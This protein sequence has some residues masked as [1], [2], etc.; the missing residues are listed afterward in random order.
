MSILDVLPSLRA[1]APVRFDPELWP[2]TTE[3]RR[4]VVWVDGL[5]LAE[6][7]DTVGVAVVRSEASPAVTVTRVLAVS[8]STVTVDGA[9][10][11]APVRGAAVCNRHPLGPTS[12]VDVVTTRSALGAVTLPSDVRAGDVLAMV[13]PGG[14]AVLGLSDVDAGPT[15]DVLLRSA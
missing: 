13:G 15:R 7:V 14:A 12:L 8:G 2:P 3:C 10:G 9:Y 5:D 11:R 1:A 4:G 6:I